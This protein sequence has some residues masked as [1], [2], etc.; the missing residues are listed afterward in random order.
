MWTHNSSI[1]SVLN[2]KEK[3]MFSW[4]CKNSENVSFEEI[5]QPTYIPLSNIIHTR[6]G[7][8]LRIL[9]RAQT[10]YWIYD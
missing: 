9:A 6:D 8:R 4:R 3:T 7:R 2:L 5:T 10:G 1:G